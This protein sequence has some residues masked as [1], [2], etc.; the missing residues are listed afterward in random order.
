MTNKS[1]YAPIAKDNNWI[2]RLPKDVSAGILTESDANL[3][4]SYLTWKMSDNGISGKRQT[5]LY[6]SI[7]R[8]RM[9]AGCS[10]AELDDTAFRSAVIGVRSHDYADWT[11]SD[12]IGQSKAFC[13]WAIA[14]GAMPNLSL[15]AVKGVKTPKAPKITKTPAELPTIDEIY[16][17]MQ[18][19]AC[20]VQLQAL[21]ATAFWSGARISEILRLNW[22]DLVFSAHHV[23]LRIRDTKTQKIRSVP[24]AEPLPYLASWRRQYPDAA[25]LPDGDNPV[26]ISAIPK[27]GKKI[28]KRSEYAAVYLRLTRLEKACGLK[29]FA[30]H[31]FRAA[32]ITNSSLAGVPDSV[33]KALHWGNQNSSMLATYTL[34]S[35]EANEREMLK[36]AGIVAEEKKSSTLPQNCPICCA[37]NGPGDQYCRMC[38]HPLSVKASE[39]QKSIEEI[40]QH[41]LANYT[42]DEMIKNMA[43]V[44]HISEEA[45]QKL[46]TWGV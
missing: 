5:K 20:G 29:H 33:I 38:G 12:I 4:K 36:R 46:L 8:L 15:T 23:T 32:N 22:S 10:F 26:F 14:Q 24:C 19:P 27:S 13:R 39:T 18:H 44:L 37:L 17:I 41:T 31:S 6:H 28:W 43:A 1:V 40:V 30:W 45:A 16:T 11:K 21:L 3:I 9:F 42:A 25:G 7:T 2:H 35:D 34:L